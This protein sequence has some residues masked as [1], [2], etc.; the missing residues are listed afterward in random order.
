MRETFRKII[1]VDSEFSLFRK[2]TRET[3]TKVIGRRARNRETENL[4]GRLEESLKASLKT[5]TS[6]DLEF[7]QEIESPS[8]ANKTKSVFTIW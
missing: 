6:L 1:S 5:T 8:Y 3:F 7:S 4:F 2:K